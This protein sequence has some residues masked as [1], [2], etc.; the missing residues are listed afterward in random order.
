MSSMSNSILKIFITSIFTLIH[1]AGNTQ[2]SN[3]SNLTKDKELEID[4]L[5]EQWDKKTSPGTAV[6]IMNNGK[7]VYQK[8]FGM[9]N[10]EQQIPIDAKT[11]F[12]LA[13]LSAHF[14]VFA[15]Y[16]LEERG[17][18]SLDES[19]HTYLP[20]LPDFGRQIIV[21]DLIQHSSGLDDYN[22]LKTLGG[23]ST[24]DNFSN[25]DAIQLISSQQKLLF[26]P[27][28]QV[29]LSATNLVL[30]SEIISEKT[31]KQ[32]ADFMKEEI[33]APLKMNNT[34]VAVDNN[35]II[36]NV[37]LSYQ[38]IDDQLQLKDVSTSTL[39]ASNMYSTLE[40]LAKWEKHLN[41]PT[42]VK[43]EVV[44]K[45]NQVIEFT[46][47]GKTIRSDGGITFGQIGYHG[48]RGAYKSW[49]RGA[50]GG[51]TSCVT[52]L[53][54]KGFSSYVLSNSGEYYTGY[55][56]VIAAGNLNPGYFPDP[57]Q[58]DYSTVKSIKLPGSELKNYCGN[59]WNSEEGLARTITYENDS[60]R[61]VRSNGFTSALIPVDKNKFQMVLQ[62]IRN[63]IP[64]FGKEIRTAYYLNLI[65][66]R[67]TLLINYM[68]MR[69]SI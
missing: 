54:D 35:Q 39:G 66:L 29:S 61:Y 56:S 62:R 19:I 50:T 43:S 15:T 51:Y 59:Y 68:N 17:V 7:L 27:G 1:L 24:R 46:K 33:F 55:I 20:D 64:L 3:F 67:Q 9:A 36:E 21:A 60:L 12:P 37:A 38:T 41:K 34:I 18:I 58:F 52:K 31:G 65:N 13:E 5:C 40:D 8:G 16:M 44:D 10:V 69:D 2:S 4:K 57:P 26:V 48:E 45:M 22:R 63:N 32:F 53:V 6:L 49:M 47:N 42:M 14:T 28:T 23:W 11:K 30:L 25:Q